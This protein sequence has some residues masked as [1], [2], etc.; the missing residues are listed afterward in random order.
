MF[1]VYV[2]HSDQTTPTATSKLA[3]FDNSVGLTNYFANKAGYDANV[4]INTPI[5]PDA[6][7]NLYFGFQVAARNRSAPGRRRHRPYLRFWRGH[8][9]EGQH[10]LRVYAAR[11]QF[12]PC[13]EC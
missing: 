2:L 1:Y 5:T 8:I 10:G 4:K 11:T 3:F 6:S 12:R 9:R 13:S 7:G